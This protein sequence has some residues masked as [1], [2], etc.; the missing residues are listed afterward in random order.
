MILVMF[1]LIKRSYFAIVIAFYFAQR[2]M[3]A[4]SFVNRITTQNSLNQS[5]THSQNHLKP[6]IL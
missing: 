5:I 6:I 1:L 4:N 2:V 3:L